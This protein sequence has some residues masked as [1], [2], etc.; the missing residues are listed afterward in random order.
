MGR[1]AGGLRGALHGEVTVPQA[2]GTGTEVVLV[3]SGTVT[4]VSATSLSVRSTDG[5][6]TTYTVGSSTAVRAAGGTAI[7]A[8]EKDATVWVVATK[9]RAALTVVDRAGGPMGRG[10]HHDHDGAGPGTPPAPGTTTTPAPG[11][12]TSGTSFESGGTAQL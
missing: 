2:D 7:S 8:I 10:R 5:F 4:A 9:A 12:T 6:T 1:G 3:Q 11:A